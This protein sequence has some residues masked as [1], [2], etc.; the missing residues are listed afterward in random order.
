MS[1][2]GLRRI[3]VQYAGGTSSAKCCFFIRLRAV[4]WPRP[5]NR[6]AKRTSLRRWVRRCPGSEQEGSA[7]VA[8]CPQERRSGARGRSL[9]AHRGKAG[10][11]LRRGFLNSLRPTGSWFFPR[12]A[13]YEG[14]ATWRPGN[15]AGRLARSKAVLELLDYVRAKGG[16]WFAAARPGVRPRAEADIQGALDAALRDVP[17]LP[18]PAPR[19]LEGTVSRALPRARDRFAPDA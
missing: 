18:N 5:V 15:S 9:F 19:I 2:S 6:H 13:R 14:A 7:R 1:A 10:V 8:Q 17:V 4:S 16:V 11:A 3:V 12:S